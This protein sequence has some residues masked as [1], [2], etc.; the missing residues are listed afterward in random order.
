MF[1]VQQ[2]QCHSGGEVAQ[3]TYY[4]AQKR[5][6]TEI[7]ILFQ[8]SKSTIPFTWVETWSLIYT[9]FILKPNFCLLWMS[10]LPGDYCIKNIT[11]FIKVKV[12][13]KKKILIYWKDCQKYWLAVNP[14][15]TQHITE[16][17]VLPP[18]S[19]CL[20]R[21]SYTKTSKGICDGRWIKQW[22]V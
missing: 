7:S 1:R 4:R 12:E 17:L 9:I 19:K 3:H 14:D 8:M 13:W 16:L 5:A 21:R 6:R 22:D 10:A 20:S 18:T 11:V 2:K 15:P